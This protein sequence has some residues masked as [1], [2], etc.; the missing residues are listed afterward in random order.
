MGIWHYTEKGELPETTEH[1]MQF[2]ISKY[3]ERVLF[4]INC[5]E[6]LHEEEYYTGVYAVDL[7]G[8]ENEEGK[9]AYR[10]RARFFENDDDEQNATEGKYE[11]S[12]VDKWAY[13]S[14]IERLLDS[15]E[16]VG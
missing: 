15:A 16:Q 7:Y 14:D 3:S 13:I 8:V 1:D 9:C 12:D 5:S 4:H 6:R 2:F 10:T 11:I